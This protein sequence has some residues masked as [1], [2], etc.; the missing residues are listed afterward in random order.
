MHKSTDT[1]VFL[2]CGSLPIV[3][4][5]N[6]TAFGPYFVFG[7]ERRDGEEALDWLRQEFAAQ[8]IPVTVEHY[9]NYK[10]IQDFNW[11]KAAASPNWRLLG[12]DEIGSVRDG[13]RVT[14]KLVSLG[15]SGTETESQLMEEWMKLL[16]KRCVFVPI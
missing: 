14:E 10:T 13:L 15:G 4:D 6:T 12:E 16:Q 8:N 9:N 2:L 3:E 11:I 7:V 5:V 1:R